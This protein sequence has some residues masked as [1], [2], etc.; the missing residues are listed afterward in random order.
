MGICDRVKTYAMSEEYGLGLKIFRT[1]LS[2]DEKK[3]VNSDERY[4]WC[5]VRDESA[6]SRC[7][8][9][10]ADGPSVFVASFSAIST[11]PLVRGHRI[12]TTRC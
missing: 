11:R 3:P 9:A 2:N 5:R 7:R 10:G 1:F 12:A 6:I 8:R 4:G